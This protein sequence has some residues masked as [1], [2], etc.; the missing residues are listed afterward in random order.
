MQ[1]SELKLIRG[2]VGFSASAVNAIVRMFTTSLELG[3]T[4]GTI[5][6]KKLDKNYCK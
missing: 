5:I 3:R 2:G 6:R 4:L 1:D